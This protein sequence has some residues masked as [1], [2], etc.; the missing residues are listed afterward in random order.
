M[1]E[2]SP[3][4]GAMWYARQRGWPVFP[5]AWIEDGRCSCDRE[6]C[7]SPG[8][9]P[10]VRWREAATTDLTTLRCWWEK[11]PRANIG[12]PTGRVTGI[13]AVDIDVRHGGHHALAALEDEHETL[14]ETVTSLTGG[15]G[16]HRI[17]QYPD[18]G[19]RIPNSAG[20]VGIGIDI[21][22]DGGYIL[23]P[24]SNHISGKPY[25]WHGDYSPRKDPAPMPPWLVALAGEMRPAQTGG[26]GKGGRLEVP[27]EIPDGTRGDVL[28][29]A[30]CA[31]RRNGFSGEEIALALAVANEKRCVPPVTDERLDQ[32][33]R[34]CLRYDPGRF[35]PGDARL[36]P[37]PP[38]EVRSIRST[39]ELPDLDPPPERIPG[40]LPQAGFVMLGGHPGS[41]K[42]WL[43]MRTALAI[44]GGDSVFPERLFCPEPVPTLFLEGE[45]GKHLYYW[46]FKALGGNRP[47]RQPLLPLYEALDLTDSEHLDYL[48]EIIAEHEIQAVFLDP[49]G[50]LFGGDENSNEEVNRWLRRFNHVLGG[51]DI[52][53]VL[54][55]HLAKPPREKNGERSPDD[56]HSFR[57]ATAWLGGLQTAYLVERVGESDRKVACVKNREGPEHDPFYFR[58]FDLSEVGGRGIELRESV[59]PAMGEVDAR[60][61]TWLRANPGS[62]SVEEVRLALG[63]R[64]QTIAERLKYL[65]SMGLIEH[66]QNM[67]SDSA[68]RANR[69]WGYSAK[70]V[71]SGVWEPT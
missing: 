22:G 60:I 7:E 39:A 41:G 52:L 15:G 1:K 2:T 27:A 30:G 21:R 71:G 47:L 66:E 37:P 43:A 33:V 70:H 61:M 45:G 44:A 55:H 46:R 40:F 26:D 32:I 38:I 51:K 59:P 62:H 57:G 56:M 24:P 54:V 4:A 29:R 67:S 13:V 65:L 12:L 28:F 64:K 20:R 16:E 18:G 5:C 3:H 36:P 6:D 19:I 25:R 69:D 14:P 53:V 50:Q 68:G 49:L 8:K 9:H 23:V 17:F 58:V 63:K 11:W 35:G 10:L 42:S 34:S 31:M 48:G